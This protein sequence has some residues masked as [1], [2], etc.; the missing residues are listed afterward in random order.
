MARRGLALGTS[1]GRRRRGASRRGSRR[2]WPAA[3]RGRG[4]EEACSSARVEQPEP[5]VGPAHLRGGDAG[6]SGDLGADPPAGRRR[7]PRARPRGS[8]RRPGRASRCR[9]RR[10]SG[11]PPS[12]RRHGWSVQGTGAWSTAWRMAG[13]SSSQAR[14]GGAVVVVLGG[15]SLRPREQPR[16]RRARVVA[17]ARRGHGPP[18]DGGQACRSGRRA[19]TSSRLRR[20]RSPASTATS[21]HRTGRVTLARD[22]EAGGEVEQP[23]PAQCG[24]RWS[25][26]S[27]LVRGVDGLGRGETVRQGYRSTPTRADWTATCSIRSAARRWPRGDG[28]PVGPGSAR[29]T[30]RPPAERMW[31]RKSSTAGPSRGARGR[32]HGQWPDADDRLVRLAG[33]RAGGDDQA[34]VGGSLHQGLV[35]PDPRRSVIEVQPVEHQQAVYGPSRARPSAPARGVAGRE[36]GIERWSRAATR[37]LARAAHVAGVDPEGHLRSVSRVSHDEGLAAA[38]RADHCHPAIFD[39]GPGQRTLDLTHDRDRGTARVESSSSRAAGG[40]KR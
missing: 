27:R 3:P 15:V 12:S 29:S 5:L 14:V 6:P 9:G 10:R 20:T 22:T 33:G 11:W 40:A 1:P 25:G 24:G 35:A 23:D 13:R 2:S 18:S 34:G 21:G 38:G 37:T 17:R 30:D 32:G 28:V 36:L 8:P 31:R 39:E 7:T 26:A 16:R 19:P 4:A